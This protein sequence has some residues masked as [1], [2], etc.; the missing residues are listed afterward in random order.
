MEDIVNKYPAEF[1]IGGDEQY[2]AAL[3]KFQPL[4]EIGVQ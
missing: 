3:S 2:E 1:L 4:F